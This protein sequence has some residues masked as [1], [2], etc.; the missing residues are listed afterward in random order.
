MCQLPLCAGNIS[1]TKPDKVPA[2][3][4]LHSSGKQQELK[5]YTRGTNLW[6]EQNKEA[7]SNCGSDWAWSREASEELRPQDKEFTPGKFKGPK[8][9]RLSGSVRNGEKAG[10]AEGGTCRDNPGEELER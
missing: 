5:P 7:D 2:L 6:R 9:G 1:V 8:A 3:R 10:V 4:S